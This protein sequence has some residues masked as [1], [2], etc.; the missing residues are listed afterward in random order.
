MPDRVYTL[1]P[2][3][4]SLKETMAIGIMLD[5]LI[6]AVPGR[7]YDIMSNSLYQAT[8][9]F[10]G[11]NFTQWVDGMSS[12]LEAQG[13]A[14]VIEEEVPSPRTNDAGTVVNQDEITSWKRD[15]VKV[16]GSIKLRLSPNVKSSIPADKMETAKSLVEYLQEEYGSTQIADL[17]GFFQTALNAKFNSGQHPDPQINVV[18]NAFARLAADE[19]VIPELLKAMILLHVA[20]IQSITESI[21]QRYDKSDLTVA[22]VREALLTHYSHKQTMSGSHVQKFSNVKRKRD[23]PKYSNQQQSGNSVPNGGDKAEKK[24]KD[25]RGQRGGKNKKDKG[26]GKQPEHAHAH[27]T[28]SEVVGSA[29]ISALTPS[30]ENVKTSHV[31]L[32][33]PAGTKVRQ[34]VE[35]PAVAADKAIADTPIAEGA[36]NVF[37]TAKEL[38]LQVTPQIYREIDSVVNVGGFPVN[39]DCTDDFP[40]PRASSSK[41]QIDDEPPV[42]RARV[43]DH[44]LNSFLFDGT[45]DEQISWDLSPLEEYLREE[46]MFGDVEVNVDD[47]IAQ[48]AGLT[49]ADR[50]C[51]GKAPLHGDELGFPPSWLVDSGASLHV[52]S[53]ESDLAGYEKLSEPIVAQTAS[54]DTTLALHDDQPT[55]EEL[56]SF[57]T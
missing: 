46:N 20:G 45:I 37:A 14:Y 15:D 55:S 47:A 5:S 35:K 1:D 49:G 50:Q 40:T 30:V 23:D 22:V 34:V 3:H 25:K 51:K 52:T 8:F 36:K 33:T 9:L 56:S 38:D 4:P 31:A 12:W 26:K 42:K 18:T 21:L 28:I 41:M 7:H 29:R 11:N 44:G 10:E 32:I 48:A 19:I 24:K 27:A 57:G 54:K 17:F 43:D 6:G 13:L 53:E 39:M 16:R 2:M